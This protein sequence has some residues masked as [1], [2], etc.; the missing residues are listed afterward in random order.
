MA[1]SLPPFG[2][3]PV[4][5]PTA[6][7]FPG[8]T[9]A[10]DGMPS[11]GMPA[12]NWGRASATWG[13]NSR[14]TSTIRVL[15]PPGGNKLP[16]LFKGNFV[17]YDR[18]TA[19]RYE[20][21]ENSAG[22]GIGLGGRKVRRVAETS[23]LSLSELNQVL[24]SHGEAY[25][26]GNV[27]PALRIRDRFS[28]L[29][30]IDAVGGVSGT[31][32]RTS[33][34]QVDMDIV[35]AGVARGI[36]YWTS[37]RKIDG[38]QPGRLV[39]GNQKSVSCS[40]LIAPMFFRELAMDAIPALVPRIEA[41]AMAP[42]TEGLR[43][44]AV[45]GALTAERKQ[46]PGGLLD[47]FPPDVQ[48][49]DYSELVVQRI[50]LALQGAPDLLAS[51]GVPG[52]AIPQGLTREQARALYYLRLLRSGDP[53]RLND[54]YAADYQQARQLEN[55]RAAQPERKG[56]DPDDAGVIAMDMADDVGD[57]AIVGDDDFEHVDGAP[58]AAR[59]QGARAPAPAPAPAAPAPPLAGAFRPSVVTDHAQRLKRYHLA[60]HIDGMEAIVEDPVVFKRTTGDN[61]IRF[62]LIPVAHNSNQDV[63]NA[64]GDLLFAGMHITE[65]IPVGTI[66]DIEGSDPPVSEHA[67][68]HPTVPDMWMSL[69]GPMPSVYMDVVQ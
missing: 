10:S 7:W 39:R 41:V 20:N 37:G 62:Q 34:L 54:V 47:P 36:N 64:Q 52:S 46:N 65:V 23:V 32:D 1:D 25:L 55:V 50:Y 31:R 58:A 42:P 33:Q 16:K 59:V 15:L 26:T 53:A 18:D 67:F 2:V 3:P 28:P 63:M 45:T 49:G 8:P 9:G 40:F 22:S 30:Y 17:F 68:L 13:A 69:M 44:H 29:G 66:V 60:P 5:V 57:A 14:T 38:V 19:V 51:P 21:I 4:S 43:A 61:G 35:M 24:Y 6:G 48:Q 56:A 12:T 27:P 11:V